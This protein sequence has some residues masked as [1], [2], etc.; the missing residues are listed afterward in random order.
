MLLFIIIIKLL[1][2]AN[3]FDFKCVKCFIS[4][5]SHNNIQIYEI[6]ICNR[7]CKNNKNNKN[8]RSCFK[9]K[10]NENFELKKTILKVVN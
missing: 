8:N 10:E 4:N 5:Q 2:I 1:F 9:V 7:D 3:I 6:I